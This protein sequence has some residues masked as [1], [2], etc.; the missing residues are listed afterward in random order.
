MCF[1]KHCRRFS[2][3]ALT[4][5]S[6]DVAPLLVVSPLKLYSA[7]AANNRSKP[8]N[9]SAQAHRISIYHV[10]VSIAQIHITSSSLVPHYGYVQSIPGHA[11]GCDHARLISIAEGGTQRF[12]SIISQTAGRLR[13]VT[14]DCLTPR[15]NDSRKVEQEVESAEEEAATGGVAE[16]VGR[17]PTR[18]RGKAPAI[19][20]K[21]GFSVT[22]YQPGRPHQ[23]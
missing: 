3:R 21:G 18:C 19:K 5:S 13:D 9:L 6:S 11:W 22:V 7:S 1:S 20:V 23:V 17:P 14:E 8:V 4:R 12:T 15:G 10:V 16:H 2:S